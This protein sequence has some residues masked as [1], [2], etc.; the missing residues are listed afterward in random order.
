MQKH[1]KDINILAVIIIYNP[2]LSLLKENIDAFV[3]HVNHVY[4]WDNSSASVRHATE[5]FLHNTYDNIICLE[6]VDENKGISYGL[7]KGWKY[8]KENKFNLVLTMDQD[9]KFQSFDIYLD[10]VLDKWE[11]EGFCL[12]GPTPNLHL[13]KTKRTGF[14]KCADIITSGMLVPIE[15]MDIANGYC[16]DFFVDAIDFDF[17]YKLK[18][19]GYDTFMDNESNLIQIFGTPKYKSICGFKIHAYGYSPF[20]LYGIFRNHIITWRRYHYPNILIRHIIKH[21]LLNYVIKGVL[22][23]ECDKWAKIKAVYKGIVDGFK[24]KLNP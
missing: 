11:Q 3:N 23:V 24:F 4:I 2:D 15:L 9:S 22:L 10:R 8:A 18:E 13:R 5:M 17:C 19:N 16:L 21:Y 1:P 6:G 20:R 12:C 7:N 14:T